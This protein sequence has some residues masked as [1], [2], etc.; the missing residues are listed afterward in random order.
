MLPA[1][2]FICHHFA[3]SAAPIQIAGR[4]LLAGESPEQHNSDTYDR[5][6]DG[7]FL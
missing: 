2:W 3:G 7:R 5:N 6:N 4:T 1:L